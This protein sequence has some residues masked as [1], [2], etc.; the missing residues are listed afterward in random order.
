MLKKL[1]RDAFQIAFLASTFAD[2]EEGT[3]GAVP[4]EMVV[5]LRA[6]SA[7]LQERAAKLI[8]NGFSNAFDQ[9]NDALDGL[10]SDDRKVVERCF[11][12]V[13]SAA[14]AV[15]LLIRGNASD[16]DLTNEI[17]AALKSAAI[18]RDIDQRQMARAG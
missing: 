12:T 10:L 18:R 2:S 7:R 8:H 6:S 16:F 13:C 15:V 11:D 17:R 5:K 4:I 9:L 14:R 3:G 1:E